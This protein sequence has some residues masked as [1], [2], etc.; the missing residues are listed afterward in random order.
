MVA[1]GLIV[2]LFSGVLCSEWAML[3][4]YLEELPLNATF[5]QACVGARSLLP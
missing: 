5:A 4:P 1:N 2:V 3:I